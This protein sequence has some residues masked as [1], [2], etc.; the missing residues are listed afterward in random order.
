M[1]TVEPKNK[2][3]AHKKSAKLRYDKVLSSISARL[4][5]NPPKMTVN[6]HNKKNKTPNTPNKAMRSFLIWEKVVEVNALMARHVSELLL[7]LLLII[8]I[9]TH[10][11]T[12][13]RAYSNDRSINLIELL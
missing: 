6:A 12:H 1:E 4:A 8:I 7:L 10:E 13:M 2:A 5:E 11:H 3:A 9:F